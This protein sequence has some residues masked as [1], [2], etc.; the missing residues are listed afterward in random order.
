MGLEAEVQTTLG[1]SPGVVKVVL[2]GSRATGCE[3]PLSDCDFKVDVTDF[4]RVAEDLPFLMEPL[5]PISRQWDRLANHLVYMLM[6]HGPTKVDLLFDHPHTPEPPWIPTGENLAR[7]DAHFWDWI[8]WIAGKQLGNHHSL[9]SQELSKLYTHL[10]HAL[11]VEQND[12]LGLVIFDCDGVLVDT[13]PIESQ[14][15]SALL[16]GLGLD[17]E[18]DEVARK[19]TGISD[20]DLWA[21]FESDLGPPCPA[22][23]LSDTHRCLSID[24]DKNYRPCRE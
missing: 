13:E 6:L 1:N 14:A 11:D 16:K 24:T 12:P 19:V 18:P 8:L 17:I 2:V 23:S 22:I 9:V 4:D 15:V 3:T 21:I 5:Q 7:I 10:L 20:R